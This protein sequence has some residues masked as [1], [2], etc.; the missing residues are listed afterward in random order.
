MSHQ[1]P[2]STPSSNGSGDFRRALPVLF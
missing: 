2:G 1:S